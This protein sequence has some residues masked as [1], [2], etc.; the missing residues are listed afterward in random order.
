MS[1]HKHTKHIPV[2]KIETLNINTHLCLQFLF[3]FPDRLYWNFE[4]VSRI[5]RWYLFIFT[6]LRPAASKVHHTV[7]T[8]DTMT[9]QLH[10][11]MPGRTHMDLEH[12][13]RMRKYKHKR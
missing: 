6:Q 11:T 5:D 13:P 10:T 8:T 9:H 7:I 12:I 2:A 3:L 1:T 4:G